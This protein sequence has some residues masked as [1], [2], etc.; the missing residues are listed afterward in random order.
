MASVASSHRQR[1]RKELMEWTI[2]APYEK[3]RMGKAVILQKLVG[4]GKSVSL[5]GPATVSR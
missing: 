4:L 5:P 3:T 2:T 1:L